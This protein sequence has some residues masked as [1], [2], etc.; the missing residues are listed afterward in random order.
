MEKHL[1]G[2]DPLLGWLA[3]DGYGFHEGYFHWR[4]TVEQQAVPVRLKGYARRGFDQGLGRSLWFVKGAE[5]GRIADDDLPFRR[6]A[7]ARPLERRRPGLRLC[8]RGGTSGRS[9]TWSWPPAGISRRWPR[10]SPSRRRRASCAG[11]PADA[12][13]TASEIVCGMSADEAAGLTDQ[14]LVDLPSDGVLP[15]FEIWRQRIQANWSKE[16]VTS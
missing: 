3:L 7:P 5:V 12:T 13:E 14:A 16:P 6:V 10:A 1:A 11:N 4:E 8:R 15:A 9:K 2:L